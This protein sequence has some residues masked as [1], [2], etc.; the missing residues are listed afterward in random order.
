M[1]AIRTLAVLYELGGSFTSFVL[2]FVGRGI[3]PVILPHKGQWQFAENHWEI[4]VQKFC[5][6]KDVVGSE[7]VPYAE[8][9]KRAECAAQLMLWALA[10]NHQCPLCDPVELPLYAGTVSRYDYR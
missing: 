9:L 10:K 2:A 5:R 6:V 8:A 4:V 3:P 1:K 7:E